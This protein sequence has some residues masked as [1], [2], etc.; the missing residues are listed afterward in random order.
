MCMYM[1]AHNTSCSFSLNTAKRQK[2]IF[3]G[4]VE[5]LQAP[6]W[7]AALSVLRGVPGLRLYEKLEWFFC[8]L[9]DL[10]R[11]RGRFAPGVSMDCLD[12]TLDDMKKAI[13]YNVELKLREYMVNAAFYE[14][15]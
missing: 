2:R 13:P 14:V 15:L 5:A 4:I 8:E 10:I 12:G 1:L 9:Y 7:D 3:Q 6:T 11:M